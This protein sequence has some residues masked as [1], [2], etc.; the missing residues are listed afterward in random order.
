LSI[1]LEQTFKWA[2]K[3]S[4]PVL[5]LLLGMVLSNLRLL[6]TASPSYDVVDDYLVPVAIPLLLFR[7]NI[8]RILRETGSMFLAFHVAAV[9]TV[10]GAFLAAFIFRGSFAHLPEVTGIMTGSYIGGGV[11]FVAI[12]DSYGISE[13]LT[14]PLL[15]ADNFIMAGMFAVLLVIAGSKV[16]RRFYPHPHSLQGDK[17]DV[18]ALAARHWRRKEISLLDIAQALAIAF[19]IAAISITITRFL[20][21]Q[22]ESRIVQSVF[23]NPFVLITFLTVT[24]STLCHRWTDKIQGAEDLG[25]YLLYLFFFVIGLRADL[26]EVV[27]KL[28]ILFLFCLVMAATNLI[29]T[30]TVGKLLR[31]NLEELLL[32]VN[33]TLGGAPSAAA[34]AISRGWSNLVLP[35]LLAGIWGYVIGTF[36]GILVT[37]VLFKL[38]GR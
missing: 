26:I 13:N 28:P 23:A 15:V 14:N 9:G 8:I 30:L 2:A 25:M 22:V 35:G 18:T 32:S 12:K 38:F 3:L 5:A 21:G 6:P 19:V 11:N 37:E 7:A 1:W 29:F 33:A 16:F 24:I 34:M 4:G 31:L 27:T 10:V 20:K 36:V 17:E